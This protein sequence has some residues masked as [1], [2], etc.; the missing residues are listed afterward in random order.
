MTYK[1]NTS[2]AYLRG[3]KSIDMNKDNRGILLKIK[4]IELRQKEV[5]AEWLDLDIKRNIL[6]RKL[7][8][9]GLE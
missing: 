6:V 2:L 9:E 3:E 7:E 4:R 8:G 5:R 1:H